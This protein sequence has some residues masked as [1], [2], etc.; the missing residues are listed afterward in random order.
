MSSFQYWALVFSVMYV[1]VWAGGF[2]IYG[3]HERAGVACYRAII[4]SVVF[5]SCCAGLLLLRY[6][7]GLVY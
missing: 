5:C 3:M 6:F 4:N 2:L 1:T 7:I